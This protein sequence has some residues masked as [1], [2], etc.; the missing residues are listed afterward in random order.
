MTDQEII[1]KCAELMGCEYDAYGYLV[2]H[3]ACE[4]YLWNPITNI[5]DTVTLYP[6][7]D[8][9]I[10]RKEQVT[11]M[12]TVLNTPLTSQPQTRAGAQYVRQS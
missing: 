4:R 10:I 6:R 2:D 12:N 5:A 1:K 7:V 3:E 8:A 9:F 11:L